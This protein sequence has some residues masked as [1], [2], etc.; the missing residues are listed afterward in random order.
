MGLEDLGAF[1][2]CVIF[3]SFL[4]LICHEKKVFFSKMLNFIV[5]FYFLLTTGLD[6]L[7]TVF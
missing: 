1:T 3:L 7:S 4:T 6:I 2:S 5:Q